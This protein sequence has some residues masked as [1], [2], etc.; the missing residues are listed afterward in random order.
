MIDDDEA[1]RKAAVEEE[2]AKVAVTSVKI[3]DDEKEVEA[4]EN[5]DEN[6]DD[7]QKEEDGEKEAEKEDEKEDEAVEAKEDAKEDD[8]VAKKIERL[9]R[10]L[11]R[12][13]EKRRAAE[14]HA[15]ALEAKLAANPEVALT[16]EDVEARAERKASEKQLIKEF[17][18][19]VEKLAEGAKSQLKLTSKKFDALVEDVTEDIGIIPGEI[20]GVLGDLDNGAAVLAHL[21]QNVDEFEDIYKLKA[22]PAKLGL[23]IARLATKLENK[24]K[25][26]PKPISQV[27][28]GPEPMGG[29]SAGGDRIAILAAK[30]NLTREEMDEYVQA[31]NAEI[32]QKRK[33]GRVNL[34]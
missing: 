28:D 33:N 7:E 16:E 14:K 12:E 24:S 25:A 27:P 11:A 23:E 21:L 10:K 2:R 1:A 5:K 8:K 31:R 20:I 3:E 6:K 19:T 29:K 34:R 30:K 22:K 26:K 32:A 17:E 9:E 15:K 18:A 13:A 4:K